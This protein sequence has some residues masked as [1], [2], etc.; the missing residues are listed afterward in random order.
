MGQ[1]SLKFILSRVV[2]FFCNEIEYSEVVVD[3]VLECRSGD[4]CTII[5]CR[6]Y[7]SCASSCRERGG[8][9]GRGDQHGSGRSRE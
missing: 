6:D 4:S 1:L 5:G 8:D 9:G 3:R 7:Q 2:Q